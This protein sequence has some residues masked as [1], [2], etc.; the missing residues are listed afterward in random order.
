M[1]T[2]EVNFIYQRLGQKWDV[3]GYFHRMYD[4]PSFDGPHDDEWE[5]DEIVVV[6]DDGD[7]S[8]EM[9]EVFVR[10]FASTEMISLADDIEIEAREL[11]E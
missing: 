8:G 11:I 2:T 5:L 9:A 1:H 3:T 10:K 4:R 6:C 7:Q